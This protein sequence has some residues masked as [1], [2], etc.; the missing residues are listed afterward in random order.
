MS[1]GSVMIS[2]AVAIAITALRGTPSAVTFDSAAE[3][4]RPR[5]REKAKHILDA[6]VRHARPQNSCPSVEII[7]TA[8]NA[9]VVSDWLKISSELPAP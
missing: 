3:P 8:L 7:T 6:L 1:A 2:A 9:A 5:S 4:G